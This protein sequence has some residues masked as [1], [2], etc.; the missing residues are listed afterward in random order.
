MTHSEELTVGICGIGGF[1]GSIA[2]HLIQDGPAGSPPLRLA[3]A[4]DP[5][6]R[7]LP[8]RAAK[9]RQ[10]GIDIYDDFDQ[11]LGRDDVRGVWLPLPI[12][13]HLPFTQRA[14]AAGRHVMCE[15]PAAGCIDDTD[16]MIAA[17]D[18]A[19]L[20]VLVGFQD[21]YDPTTAQV[22]QLLLNGV[23][24]EV[25]H[26]TLHACWPRGDAYFRRSN[27]AGRIKRHGAWVLDSPA[28]NALSHYI[29]IVLLLMGGSLHESAAP[30][31]I[32]AELY[33][34]APIE[35][36]DTISARATLAG[37]ATFLVLLTH[38]C[39]TET[40]P[41]IH[42]HGTRGSIVRKLGKYRITSDAGERVIPHGFGGQV[43]PHVVHA[44]ARAMTSPLRDGELTATL[45]IA[46]SHALFISGASEATPVYHIDP[47][48]LTESRGARGDTV[49]VVP[50]IDLVFEHCAAQNLML[51]ESRRFE[52]TQ[53]PG[54][55]DLR[56]YRRFT[57]GR[58]PAGS[59]PL[60]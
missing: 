35:N 42:L 9:L 32:E 34:A 22:K 28:N 47:M 10:A 26:A 39:A 46:R 23:I 37:G 30:V 41:V 58:T 24:G 15:K 2:D 1:A 6:W 18:R 56:G 43:Y 54:R 5:N 27:W 13:L 21:V 60:T 53:P 17:R 59:V 38:A 48:L 33:R 20:T 25:T 11:L 36:Y 49:R 55:F 3:A 19:G 14:L 29:N 31:E 50:N 45:E 12:D 16:A 8:D 51:H 4:C 7:N 40:E 57:G 44:W 52:F